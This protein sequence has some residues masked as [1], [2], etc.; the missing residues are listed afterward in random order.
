MLKNTPICTHSIVVSTSFTTLMAHPV[1]QMSY[2]GRTVLQIRISTISQVN[3]GM[4]LLNHSGV[5]S[6]STRLMI[7]STS[8]LN[9]SGV[10][11]HSTIPTVS[12]STLIRANSST[13]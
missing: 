9:H 11:N 6:N 8:L 1:G 12:N 13:L 5:V 10:V 4:L 7:S 2:T 3:S